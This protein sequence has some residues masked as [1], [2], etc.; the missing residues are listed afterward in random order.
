MKKL[1]WEKEILKSKHTHKHTHNLV[2]ITQSKLQGYKNVLLFY[3]HTMNLMKEKLRKHLSFNYIKR[4]KIPDYKPN[5]GK[6]F[7]HF[8]GKN[9]Q[10]KWKK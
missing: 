5:K 2:E 7:R 3:K 10:K 9:S 8:T 6:I 4:N 1:N